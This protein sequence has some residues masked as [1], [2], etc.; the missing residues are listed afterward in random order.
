MKSGAPFGGRHAAVA[1]EAQDR[2]ATSSEVLLLA[3]ACVGGMRGA[4]RRERC[5]GSNRAP[6]H[7]RALSGTPAGR[8]A[9]PTA[10]FRLISSWLLKTKI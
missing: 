6:A 2:F 8:Q 7:L 5:S 9:A 1:G 10:A 4:R 3:Q